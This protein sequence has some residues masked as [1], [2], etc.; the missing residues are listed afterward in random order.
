[1]SN[2]GPKKVL[3]MISSRKYNYSVQAKT[4]RI[5]K[6]LSGENPRELSL[7]E[8][9][10]IRKLSQQ[11]LAASMN[12]K[13]PNLSKLERNSDMYISTLRMYVEAMGGDL[14]IIAK[15]PDGDVRIS[16]FRD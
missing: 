12:K 13:Q 16:Q 14:E 8:L 9:R 10:Q 6:K 15:F 4:S 3:I 11:N 5:S 2:I 1:M 7:S